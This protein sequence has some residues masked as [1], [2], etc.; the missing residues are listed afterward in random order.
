MIRDLPTIRKLQHDWEGAA[1]WRPPNTLRHADCKGRSIGVPST[2]KGYMQG[3][4]DFSPAC[5]HPMRSVG[6]KS[7]VRRIHCMEDMMEDIPS[8]LANDQH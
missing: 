5:R 3:T 2:R 7:S 4:V 1:P 8:L 6:L